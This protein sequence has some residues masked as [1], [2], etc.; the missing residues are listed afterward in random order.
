MGLTAPRTLASG[1]GLGV[2]PGKENCPPEGW[3]CHP[4]RRHHAERGL[5]G[6]SESP[7]HFCAHI[8]YGSLSIPPPYLPTPPHPPRRGHSSEQG[9][10][11][12]ME[13][14]SS[15]SESEGNGFTSCWAWT[16]RTSLGQASECLS[17]KRGCLGLLAA[18]SHAEGSVANKT[19]RQPRRSVEAE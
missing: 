15:Q 6:Q 11:L 8:L 1:R 9:R 7:V 3:V 10:D 19:V 16:V 12:K 13:E 4:G 18:P 17:E 14:R 2:L 5:W